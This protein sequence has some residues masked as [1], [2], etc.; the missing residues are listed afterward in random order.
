MAIDLAVVLPMIDGSLDHLHDGYTL[1]YW[2]DRA[3]H[4]E[5]LASPLA[6]RVRAVQTNGSFGLSRAYMER[7]PAL[8]I[9]CIVGAG[10]EGVDLAAARERGI[11]VTYGPGVNA[12]WVAEHAWGLLLATVRRIPWF[13][14]GVREGRWNELRGVTASAAGRRLGIFGFGNIGREVAQRGLGFGM[15]IAYCSR[16]RRND[17]PYAYFASLRDLAAWCDI[18]VVCAPGG[19]A[20]RHAVDAGVLAALGPEG[21]L[22]NVSR[23]SVV[24]SGALAAALAE[25]SLAGAGLDVLESEP[26]VPPALAADPRV[27]LTPHIAGHTHDAVAAMMRLVRANLDAHFAGQP[28]LTPVP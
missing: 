15:E 1:H 2:P 26:A 18:L 17:V 11:V 21:Y 20:T 6:A 19:P 27:V 28:V 25:R 5:H 9:V 23:G 4:A 13:D 22:V 8:E 10:V 12:A 3:R 7:L 16:T 14:R 24:D